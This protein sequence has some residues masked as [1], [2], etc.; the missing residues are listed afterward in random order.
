MMTNDVTDLAPR[1]VELDGRALG[2]LATGGTETAL[3][4]DLL[5][6]KLEKRHF[7]T[8]VVRLSKPS[9][10]QPCPQPLLDRLAGECD[11]VMVGVV[12]SDEAAAVAALDA[13]SLERRGVAC[14][15]L[16]TG[17]VE[18]ASRRALSAQGYNPSASVL[19]VGSSPGTDPD[20]AQSTVDFCYRAVEAALTYSAAPG[21]QPVKDAATQRNGQ[22]RC[23]C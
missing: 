7:L 3:F 14:A 18:S 19:A 6:A 20:A 9:D 13:A 11:V 17:C 2:V 23:E 12:A 15:V 16:V 1:P 10:A 21:P 22:V 8:T 5:I 4:L